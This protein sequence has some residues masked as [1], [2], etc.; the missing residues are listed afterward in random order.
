MVW[1]ALAGAQPRGCA[2][3]PAPAR[4]AR[5][6]WEA[7]QAEERA[8][9]TLPA[10]SLPPMPPP[11]SLRGQQAWAAALLLPPTDAGSEWAQQSTL[12]PLSSL[13][14]PADELHRQPAAVELPPTALKPA[15]P[16]FLLPRLRTPRIDE[17][18][19]RSTAVA[20]EPCLPSGMA[21][22]DAAEQV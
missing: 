8:R 1:I 20:D 7:A 10:F 16:R 19:R 6:C 12:V 14:E 5:L 2:L 18:Q 21:R 13:R 15:V 22:E 17:W 3:Q 9:P 11:P 4:P